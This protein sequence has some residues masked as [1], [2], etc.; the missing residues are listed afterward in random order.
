[1]ARMRRLNPRNEATEHGSIPP[2]DP[3]GI[4]FLRCASPA[5]IKYL[6]SATD[7]DQHRVQRDER[8][9]F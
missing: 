7:D 4:S 1:M 2:P 3:S 6:Q 5:G 8:E 9:R